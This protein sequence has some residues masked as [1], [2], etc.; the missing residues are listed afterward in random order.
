MKLS[1]RVILA[2]GSPRRKQLLEQLGIKFEV[3]PSS[4]DEKV[5]TNVPA[6]LVKILCKQK[7]IDVAE[8]CGDDFELVIG[9][10]TVVSYKG[11]ILGKPKTKEE[12]VEML[13][14]IQGEKHQVYTGVA[15]VFPDRKVTIVRNTHVSM[16]P[17]TDEQIHDYV[18]TGEPL[19]KAG[20]YAIQGR[21]AAYIEK[22]DGD[23]NNVVGLPLSAVV[24]LLNDMGYD[25]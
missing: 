21:G 15:L 14:L 11:K 12:A 10:D 9:A 23:Y 25:I 4:V 7:A 18:E 22:I 8:K 5:T 2:S 19:D 13:K 24:K 17:M 6:D 16:Y 1:G 20:A 3:V